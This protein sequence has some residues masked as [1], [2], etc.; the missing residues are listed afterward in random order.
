ML[1]VISY[2]VLSLGMIMYT[3]G[4]IKRLKSLTSYTVSLRG[5]LNR[6]VLPQN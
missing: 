3:D 5:K 2:L 4:S 1:S 6:L